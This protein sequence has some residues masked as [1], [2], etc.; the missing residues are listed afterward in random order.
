MRGESTC[1]CLICSIES[2][3][4]NQ[5]AERERQECYQQFAASRSLLSVFPS[6][7]DLVDYLH[8]CRNTEDGTNRTDG[9]LS[10]LLQAAARDGDTGPLR[11]MLL[12]VFIPTL[13]ATS[14]SVAASY[15]SLPPED[16]AQHA[17]VSLLEALL[18]SELHGR[19]SHI[20]F[21]ISRLLKRN[22][23]SWAHRECRFQRN[24]ANSELISEA[25]S[26]QD[27]SEPI[28][29][30]A[31]LGHLLSRCQQRGWL[32]SQELELLVQFKFEDADDTTPRSSAATHSNASR[33]RMK[34][35]VS[36]LRRIART[37][38]RKQDEHGQGSLF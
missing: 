26:N 1:R 12:L 38:L 13:H 34:R 17:V 10:E 23:F 3:L 36:K 5:L 28:E 16:I 18:C 14:R 24:A 11:E 7:S 9:L 4:M 22:T 20:A 15:P 37:R 35:V 29:R 27:G 32:T 33:Q 25:P 2:T 6:A 19:S 8:S 31:I 21:S 30:T